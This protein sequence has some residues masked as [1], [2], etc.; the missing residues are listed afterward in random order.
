MPHRCCSVGNTP[1]TYESILA[2][3]VTAHAHLA[4]SAFEG[5]VGAERILVFVTKTWGSSAA[6]T[7][8]KVLAVFASFFG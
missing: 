1:E 6:G 2:R 3:F 4:L 7:R 5:A 8:R